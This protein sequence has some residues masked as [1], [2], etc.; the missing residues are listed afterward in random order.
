[1]CDVDSDEFKSFEWK[2][3]KLAKL[4]PLFKDEEQFEYFTMLPLD[5]K[6]RQEVLKAMM[7]KA[8]QTGDKCKD[9]QNLCL[10]E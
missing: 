6:Q 8:K 1:M 10:L 3:K 2:K 5:D 7:E 4:L 9:D